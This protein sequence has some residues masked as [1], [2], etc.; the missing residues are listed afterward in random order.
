MSGTF[1]K[2]FKIVLRPVDDVRLPDVAV[3]LARGAANARNG[4]LHDNSLNIGYTGHGT[5]ATH[6]EM[7]GK[8]RKEKKIPAGPEDVVPRAPP[9][10]SFL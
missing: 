7:V 10:P 1:P 3:I 9:L 8:E 4:T 6:S 2:P 5:L